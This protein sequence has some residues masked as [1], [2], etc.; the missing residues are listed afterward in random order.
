[1]CVHVAV[2]QK[3]KFGITEQLKR[4][5]ALLPG[6]CT[7]E[8]HGPS[9]LFVLERSH[10][11]LQQLAA[12]NN[13]LK[14]KCGGINIEEREKKVNTLKARLKEL[15]KENEEVKNLVND[16]EKKNSKREQSTQC[17]MINQTGNQKQSMST[18]KDIV[19]ASDGP[20]LPRVS[21]QFISVANLLSQQM[22]DVGGTAQEL[23]YSMLTHPHCQ[24][25]PVTATSQPTTSTLRSLTSSQAKMIAEFEKFVSQS[26]MTTSQSTLQT[27]AMRSQSD[28]ARLQSMTSQPGMM[29]IPHSSQQVITTNNQS[30][31]MTS[32]PR[33]MTS[34][35]RVVTHP[36]P[37]NVAERQQTSRP[38]HPP[39]TPMSTQQSLTNRGHFA[40]YPSNSQSHLS[41]T[42]SLSMTRSNFDDLS[43]HNAFTGSCMLDPRH[44]TNENR[45]TTQAVSDFLPCQGSSRPNV[46]ISSSLC[47]PGVTAGANCWTQLVET[48]RETQAREISSYSVQSLT[49]QNREQR[50]LSLPIQQVVETPQSLQ[51]HPP[52]QQ[53]CNNASHGLSHRQWQHA[54]PVS[55]SPLKYVTPHR[56]FEGSFSIN[57]IQSNRNM[58]SRPQRPS[59][60]F[61]IERLTSSQFEGEHA[62]SQS[63]FDIQSMIASRDGHVTQSPTHAVSTRLLRNNH[64]RNSRTQ[65]SH[66]N[67]L[68]HMNTSWPQENEW[69]SPVICQW[70]QSTSQS[71]HDLVI[72]SQPN[73]SDSQLNIQTS[74]AGSLNWQFI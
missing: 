17:D 61:T 3:R 29:S 68:T 1:M 60:T 5:A 59:Q 51:C 26:Q 66:N 72:R 25:M 18:S 20:V 37:R 45:P 28:S 7:C 9:H 14:L 49:G 71:L 38:C 24:R 6:D 57:A 55:Y 64:Q 39:F 8:A 22:S 56:Q 15:E 69:A 73:W 2:E 65:M 36:N 74:Q 35:Q 16:A 27:Q 43:R 31:S 63:R 21:S 58:P 41:V 33:V 34:L 46:R 4:L 12:E 40:S 50:T 44:N 23:D 19:E 13:E 70:Q 52:Q 10:H 32:S 62:S 54:Q 48:T 30:L 47:L 53:T 11:L 67:F 42:P